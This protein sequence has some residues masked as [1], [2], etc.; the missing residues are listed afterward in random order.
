MMHGRKIIKFSKNTF[1][2]LMYSTRSCKNRARS[3]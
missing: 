3:I 1:R 2:R